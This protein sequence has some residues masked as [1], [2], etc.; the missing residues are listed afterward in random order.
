MRRTLSKYRWY[1][2][3]SAGDKVYRLAFWRECAIIT[4]DTKESGEGYAGLYSHRLCGA[5]GLRGRC[6]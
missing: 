6:Q 5:G 4:V 3:F 1:I 2:F